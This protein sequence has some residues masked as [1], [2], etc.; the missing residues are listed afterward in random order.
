MR[1]RDLRA[2][3]GYYNGML[4]GIEL[5]GAAYPHRVMLLK[6]RQK[7]PYAER[8]FHVP[9]NMEYQIADDVPEELRN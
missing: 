9:V 7:W 4:A 5:T 3:R 2:A 8:E 1:H 6:Q